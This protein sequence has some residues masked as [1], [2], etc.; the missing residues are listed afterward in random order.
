MFIHAS[1]TQIFKRRQSYTHRYKYRHINT[2]DIFERKLIEKS[3][4]NNQQQQPLSFCSVF[5]NAYGIFYTPR[6]LFR[7]EGA[8]ARQLER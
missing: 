2:K 5:C 3:L 7:P 4:E 1:K 8:E 6:T